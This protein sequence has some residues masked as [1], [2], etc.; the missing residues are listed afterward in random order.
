MES[1]Q[2]SQDARLLLDV[3][4]SQHLVHVD[5]AYPRDFSGVQRLLYPLRGGTLAQRVDQNGRVE[6]QRQSSADTARVAEAL[7]M[8]PSSRI[9]VPIVTVTGEDPETR[10]DVFAAPCVVERAAQGVGDESAATASAH[11]LV[12][13]FDELVIEAYVQSHGH[14]VAHTGNPV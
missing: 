9:G 14:N 13:L 3:R 10:F 12:E 5:S 8:D 11:A 4:A 1:A 6:Q 2:E 7:V